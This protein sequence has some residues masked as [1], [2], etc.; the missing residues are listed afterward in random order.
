[1]SN[2]TD[3]IVREKGKLLD[4]RFNQFNSIADPVADILGAAYKSHP[5]R[6]NEII[7]FLKSKRVEI[8]YKDYE[9][10]AYSPLRRGEPGQLIIHKEASI[11]SWEHEFTHYLDD[12]K[13][14]F[15]GSA[16]LY[17]INYRITTELNAYT[18]EIEFIKSLKGENFKTIKQLKSNFIEEVKAVEEVTNQKLNN[19][20]ILNRIDKLLK[21]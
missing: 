4:S 2:K 15:L 12:E 18:K 19:K 1:M 7:N 13:A 14:G 20:Q 8:L 10:L 11:S 9:A 16:S 3:E 6:L 17:D 21:L 5:E